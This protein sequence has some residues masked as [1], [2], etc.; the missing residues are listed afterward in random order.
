VVSDI[1]NH[2]E[3]EAM[4]DFNDLR[5]RAENVRRNAERGY[6]HVPMTV[7]LADLVG[8]FL[9]V[10]DSM[11]SKKADRWLT[12]D[13]V[14]T[15]TGWHRKYFDKKLVSLQGRSRLE[16]WKAAGQADKVDPGIWLISPAQV[17]A[18]KPGHEAASTLAD[19]LKDEC[20]A[21][22]DDIINNFMGEN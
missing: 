22:I 21:D 18:P 10:L 1:K 5:T 15:R 17:P 19:A 2:G 12:L 8:P 7:V 9:Q 13:E 6:E 16:V 11:E 20:I 3:R 14:M 4:L